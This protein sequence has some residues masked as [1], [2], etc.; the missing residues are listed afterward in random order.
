VLCSRL[1]QTDERL[2]EVAMFGLPPRLAKAL[3]RVIEQDTW[4]KTATLPY[5]HLTQSD[6]ANMVGA[7]R[8]NVNKCLQ[9]WQRAGII[10]MEKRIITIADRIRLES[11]AD[12]AL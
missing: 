11:V 1:R 2:A 9:E 3:L 6:L 7:A 5:T 10:Q 4:D 8:E 12:S